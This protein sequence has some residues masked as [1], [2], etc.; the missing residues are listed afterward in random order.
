MQSG[1]LS[2]GGSALVA[3]AF[4]LGLLLALGLAGRL[5]RRESSLRDFYLAGSGLGL[6][7]LFLTLFATQYSG[8]TLLGFAG[9]SYRQGGTY[10]VSITGMILVTTS[11]AIYAPRLFRL[12][13]RFGYITPAD[14]VYHR[15]GSRS[16]TV[17]SVAILGWGLANYIL[18]NLVAMGHTMEEL[19]G[20]RIGFMGGVILL[21]AVMLIYESLGGMRSVAWTDVVQGVLLF[22][23][24][25]VIFWIL[26]T[27]EG[28]LPA[29]AAT[30]QQNEPAK[31]A[32][33]DGNGVR[34]W[35]S[36]MILLGLGVSIYP[37]LMQR[38]FAARSLRSLRIALAGMAFMPLITTMFAFLVGFIALSRFPALGPLESDRV[39][40]LLLADIVDRG[41]FTYW[42]VVIVFAAVVAAIM[43][44]ADSALLSVSSMFTKDIYKTHVRPGAS[45]THYLAVGKIF[46]WGLMALLVF[47]AWLALKTESSIWGLIELKLEFMIQ[48]SPVFMLGLFWRRLP[49]GAVLAGVLSGLA[50]TLTLW[51][52]AVAGV[53]P[54][55]APLGFSAGIWGLALNYTIC[56]VGGSM[57]AGQANLKVDTSALP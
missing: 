42:L 21:V 52:G 11:F 17:L 19:S 57:A 49:A 3:M 4:Y 47:F 5:S 10:V 22:V 37:H 2:L 50:L 24:C 14:Y 44:T 53:W 54:T 32:A 26:V 56:V 15:F 39:T 23:G 18:E 13:R 43:S 25:G 34:A 6:T 46:G 9:R 51:I 55:R 33:P 35:L 38:L 16:L 27:S 45:P 31:L 36:T 8:N 28:G 29:A 48:M 30:V 41:G 12:S 20:G 7:V 40:L 1:E